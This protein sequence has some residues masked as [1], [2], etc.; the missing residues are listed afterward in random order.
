MGEK[1]IQIAGLVFALVFVAVFA[2]LWGTGSDLLS[3]STQEAQDLYNTGYSFDTS[4]Y[5]NTL[6]TGRTMKNLQKE[7]DALGYS[8]S[9]K[10]TITP[11]AA[12]L[13]EKAVYRSTLQYNNN[14]VISGIKLV[15][16]S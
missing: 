10:V 14:G 12:S 7:L 13:Q 9:F 11:S 16:E 8:N 4:M 6:V 2:F 1:M 3:L 5:D 15:K